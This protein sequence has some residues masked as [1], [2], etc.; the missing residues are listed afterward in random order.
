[1]I[2]TI[3]AKHAYSRYFRK[4]GYPQKPKGSPVWQTP[5]EARKHADEAFAF[6]RIIYGVYAVKASWEDDTDIVPDQTHRTLKRMADLML[7]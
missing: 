3:G 6:S 4:F 7:V 1:M 2:Y 5:E